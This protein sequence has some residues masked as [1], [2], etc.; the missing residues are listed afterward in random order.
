[1]RHIFTKILFPGLLFSLYA[2]TSAWAGAKESSET[3]SDVPQRPSRPQY[4]IAWDDET[5]GRAFFAE[6]D[7]SHPELREARAFVEKNQYPEALEAWKEAFLSRVETFSSPED[8]P[9]KK[10]WLSGQNNSPEGLLGDRVVFKHTIE[11]DMGGLPFAQPPF[12]P[13]E[14]VDPE[15]LKTLEPINQPGLKWHHPDAFDLHAYLMWHP[16]AIFR[17]LEDTRRGWTPESRAEAIV[18]WMDIWRDYA[19]NAQR[20]AMA[21]RFEPEIRK[22]ALDYYGLEKARL[23]HMDAWAGD[24]YWRQQLVVTWQSANFLTQIHHGAANFPEELRRNLDARALAETVYY[25]VVWNFPTAMKNCGRG[26]ANQR[27]SNFYALLDAWRIMP[28][29]KRFQRFKTI[30][31]VEMNALLSGPGAD[32]GLDGAGSENSYNYMFG[33]THEYERFLAILRDAP[34]TPEWLPV[35]E[36][37]LQRRIF[38]QQNMITPTNGTLQLCKGERRVREWHHSYISADSAPDYTSIAFPYHGCWILRENWTP[39]SLYLALQS[40]RRGSGHEAEDANKI[41]LEALGRSFLVSNA[42]ESGL[43]STSWGQNTISV[44]DSGQSRRR[45]PRH[46]VYDEPHRSA[47]HTSPDFDFCEALYSSGYGVATHKDDSGSFAPLVGNVQHLRQIAFVKPL[48]LWVMIDTLIAPETEEHLYTQTW[49]LDAAFT[50]EA[51]RI[52]K[53]PRGFRT[54]DPGAP[55]LFVYQF[56]QKLQNTLH[57]AEGWEKPADARAEGVL[58]SI[59]ETACGWTNQG[60]GY[61]GST[62]QP[63]PTVRSR[64]RGRGTQRL[65]S[66]LVPDSSDKN[67]LVGIKENEKGIRLRFRDSRVLIVRFESATSDVSLQWGSTRW[68]IRAYGLGPEKRK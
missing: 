64:F 26:L 68:T 11:V 36:E 54:C 17:V 25:L 46:G 6:I 20:V 43:F 34:Y 3:T 35:F 21:F 22:A 66:I 65:I 47:W 42:G 23:A 18:R 40:A 30:L 5:F 27:V 52:L 1:M 57:Y 9:P 62:V 53:K 49:N 29:F 19:N 44:D 61:T 2:W 38:F 33:A 16:G 60:S 67:P 32:L 48:R 51:V 37:R 58:A 8:F 59:P 10:G 13:K 28:E 56:G 41:T 31:N 14:G 50:K 4:M 39:E 63:A 24:I 55:N 7:L 45:L 12:P 15:I